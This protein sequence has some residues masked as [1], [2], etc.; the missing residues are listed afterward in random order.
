MRLASLATNSGV[1]HCEYTMEYY[2]ATKRN[3]IAPSVTTWADPE[4]IILSEMHSTQKDE[5][6]MIS[7]IHGI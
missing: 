1:F 3:E 6:S 5:Y 7:F 2:T 4:N